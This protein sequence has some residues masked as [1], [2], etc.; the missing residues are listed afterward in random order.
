MSL[1]S[2]SRRTYTYRIPAD[3]TA[4]ML[5]LRRFERKSDYWVTELPDRKVPSS[6]KVKNWGCK[7]YQSKETSGDYPGE[8]EGGAI[9]E[10]GEYRYSLDWEPVPYRSRLEMKRSHKGGTKVRGKYH[11]GSHDPR[12]P[13]KLHI[14]TTV[15]WTVNEIKQMFDGE[16][17][18][19]KAEF[20]HD[21]PM[22]EASEARSMYRDLIDTAVDEAFDEAQK[23]V[24]EY[25]ENC[26]HI[27]A[28]E[29]DGRRSYTA[30][31]EDCGKEW[32]D[33]EE[34]HAVVGTVGTA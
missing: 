34:A 22:I 31:C 11:E 20:T 25:V 14:E 29:H 26:D 12:I 1:K 5:R 32:H 2:R 19:N 7:F 33:K 3:D 15:P 4:A 6:D 16:K 28:L 17:V 27:S 18:P 21:P 8:Y 10:L 23:A 24:Q 9:P 13:D 30:H